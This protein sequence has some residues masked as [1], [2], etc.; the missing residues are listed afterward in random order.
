MRTITWQF[1]LWQEQLFNFFFCVQFSMAT[2]CHSSPSYGFHPSLQPSVQLQAELVLHWAISRN[3][4]A[5]I[6]S[7]PSPAPPGWAA[8]ALRDTVPIVAG[9]VEVEVSTI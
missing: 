6:C 5:G 1:S 8:A 9:A 7:C 3:Y 4:T 2:T